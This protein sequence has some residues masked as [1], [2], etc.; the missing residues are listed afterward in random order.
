MMTL[1]TIE[2]QKKRSE[3]RGCELREREGRTEK[4]ETEYERMKEE[5]EEF[6]Q[7]MKNHQFIPLLILTPTEGRC[8]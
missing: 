4:V 8:D 6:V 1:R 5:L 2:I 7:R 3:E